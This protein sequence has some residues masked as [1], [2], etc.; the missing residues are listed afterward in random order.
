MSGEHVGLSMPEVDSQARSDQKVAAREETPLIDVIYGQAVIAASTSDAEASAR[1]KSL[2]GLGAASAPTL[3]SYME[4][5]TSGL[6]LPQVVH[7]RSPILWVVSE[8]GELLFSLEEVIDA[9]GHYSY[10]LP[11]GLHLPQGYA[12]LGHPALLAGGRGRIGGE[13]TF[14]DSEP[15]GKWVLTNK[16]GRY[17]L[18]PDRTETQLR[19]VAELCSEHGISVEV[20]FIDPPQA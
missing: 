19:N 5:A 17:G 10:P 15:P 2:Q 11:R 16:S 1:P 3:K 18:V 6:L 13:L 4:C 12:K 20:K 14:D 7:A 8:S 9:S